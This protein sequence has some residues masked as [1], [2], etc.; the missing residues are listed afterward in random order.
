M[1]DTLIIRPFR[2]LRLAI[3]FRLD[4]GLAYDWPRAFRAARRHA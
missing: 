1:I 3:V 2:I 4:R